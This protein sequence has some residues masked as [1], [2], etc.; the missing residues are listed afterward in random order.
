MDSQSNF[1]I[2]SPICL[3]NSRLVHQI[4][5]QNANTFLQEMKQSEIQVTTCYVYIY[6]L[7]IYIY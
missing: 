5:V 4:S 7:Y 1:P 6:I 3:S 2:T